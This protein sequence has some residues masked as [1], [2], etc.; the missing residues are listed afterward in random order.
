MAEYLERDKASIMSACMACCAIRVKS[1]LQ[2]CSACRSSQYCSRACQRHDWRQGG[3]REACSWRPIDDN[4]VSRRDSS[5]LHALLHEDYLRMRAQLLH[6]EL[7]YLRSNPS[8]RGHLSYKFD[9]CTPY[10]GCEASVEP[11]EAFALDN[12]LWRRQNTKARASDGRMQTH[13][14]RVADGGCDSVWLF[15]LYAAAG[16]RR[17]GVEVLAMET[18]GAEVDEEADRMHIKRLAELDILEVHPC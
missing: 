5:F 12:E 9:Y 1:E 6:D 7:V 15:P 17:K 16:D 3:H 14:M 2:R 13:V 10:V 8:A 4:N 11:E 18:T